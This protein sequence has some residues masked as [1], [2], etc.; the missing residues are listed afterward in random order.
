[1]LDLVYLALVVAP[2]T[3]AA[4]ALLLM[5]I[6]SFRGHSDGRAQ[7][8]RADVERAQE[9]PGGMRKR[10]APLEEP[11]SIASLGEGGLRAIGR[12][13]VGTLANDPRPEAARPSLEELSAL[14]ES[15]AFPPRDPLAGLLPPAATPAPARERTAA[16]APPARA[17]PAPTPA[18]A[19]APAAATKACPDCAEEVL[20]AARVC[21]HCRYRFDEPDLRRL[22]A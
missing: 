2:L 10:D 6:R 14:V 4:A 1:M 21:K 15:L 17:T 7:R 13:V 11:A 20:A 12:S 19:G 18:R 3:L 8:R 5:A 22:S 9:R 16:P